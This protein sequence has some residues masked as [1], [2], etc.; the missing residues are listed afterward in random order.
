[1][2][3]SKL[4]QNTVCLAVTFHRPG[5]GRRVRKNEREVRATSKKKD[6]NEEEAKENRADQSRFKVGKDIIE[7]E[8][9]D[10]AAKIDRDFGAWANDH[11]VESPLKRGTYFVPL[12]LVDEFYE[13]L[14]AAEIAY[15]AE[16][17]KFE[18]KYEQIKEASK[19]SLKEFYREEDF[20]PAKLFRAKCWVERKMFDF[21]PPNE[22][23]LSEKILRMELKRW[24]SMLDEAELDV[25]Y[26][27]RAG[28][29]QMIQ[30]FVN[31]LTPTE[32][33]KKRR[34]YDSRVEDLVQF[35]ELFHKR[36]VLD[37]VELQRLVNKAKRFLTDEDGMREGLMEGLRRDENIRDVIREQFSKI[38]EK[39]TELVEEAPARAVSF[40][41]DE[42]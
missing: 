13:R 25:K 4:F 31:V 27:L 29:Q 2:N 17:D 12:E 39:V 37:D 40:D 15:H 41:D 21:S 7:S 42:F 38:N 34:I 8:H 28:F 26:G 30:G 16:F 11:S 32:D 9:Y 36:N 5:K 24:K 14:D 35:M 3:E 23:K 33:G 20:Y 10:K 6:E 18:A 1:M 22:N 19:K